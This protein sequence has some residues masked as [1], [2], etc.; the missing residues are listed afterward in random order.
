MRGTHSVALGSAVALVVVAALLP[1]DGRAALIT[2]ERFFTNTAG[3]TSTTNTGAKAFVLT[4]RQTI[5]MPRFD[6]ALGVLNEVRFG[7]VADLF[8]QARATFVGRWDLI[9]AYVDGYVDASIAILAFNGLPTPD[10]ELIFFYDP[11]S[12]TCSDDSF[13]SDAQCTAQVSGSVP[14]VFFGTITGDGLSQWAGVE[15][16]A[17]DAYN[18]MSSHASAGLF[19]DPYL[20]V[21]NLT[22]SFRT[23]VKLSVTYDYTPFAAPP[24]QAVSE[25]DTVSLV[26]AA[27]LAIGVSVCGFRSNGRPRFR[28]SRLYKVRAGSAP[29]G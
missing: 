22:A 2:H 20:F 23:N 12:A 25:P 28:S 4:A 18:E 13:F 5:S 16:L 1:G 6:P 29:N 14:R 10:D 8:Y 24:P 26:A 17:I 21:D 15:P 11:I 19:S 3:Q 27:L 9:G 7:E